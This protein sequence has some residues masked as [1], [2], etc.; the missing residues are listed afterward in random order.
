[1][2]H[3]EALESDFVTFNLPRWIDLIW[4]IHQKSYEAKNVYC[5]LTYEEDVF[6]DNFIYYRFEK[7]N[8]KSMK[9]RNSKVF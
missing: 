1:M 7:F 5:H 6:H 9:Y 2:M 8:C 4:G 3:R